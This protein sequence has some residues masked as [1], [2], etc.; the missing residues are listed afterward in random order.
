MAKK[1][2]LLTR[3]VSKLA[4]VRKRARECAVL[5][6]DLIA[7]GLNASEE[8]T[9]GLGEGLS[10]KSLDEVLHSVLKRGWEGLDL[11]EE[12]SSAHDGDDV[13]GLQAVLAQIVQESEWEVLVEENPQDAWRTAGGR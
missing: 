1:F 12:F 8:G 9:L 7:K 5:G 10:G 6:P 2:L 3:S 11:L 4:Q 13:L